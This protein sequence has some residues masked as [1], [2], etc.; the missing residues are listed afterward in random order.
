MLFFF[1]KQKTAYEMRISDCSSDVCSSDLLPL[2]RTIVKDGR[3]VLGYDE[4]YSIMNDN[5]RVE[6]QLPM[7]DY[8]GING[9]GT[10]AAGDRKSVVEGKSVS[11]SVD[12]GGR[13]IIKKKSSEDNE[14]SASSKDNIRIEI[15]AI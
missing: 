4:E 8:L 11:V 12:I 14:G 15:V 5:I 2:Y 10:I 9:S 1:F 7:L 3:L 6:V 13:G